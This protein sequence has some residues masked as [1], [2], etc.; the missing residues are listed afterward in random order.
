MA[1]YAPQIKLDRESPVPLYHQIAQPIERAILSG[2]VSP[3]TRVEDEL[4]MAR[5]LQ[6][7]RPTAR[8][9]LQQL[10]GSGLIVRRRGVGTQVAPSRV[11]RPVGLS[12]LWHDIK[13]MGQKPATRIL[14]YSTSP[15]NTQVAR[16]LEV[17][18]GTLVTSISRLRLADDQ[19][20]ALL[21]NLIP[22]SWVPSA[23][24]LESIGLYDALAQ[25]GVFPASARQI[26][27]ARRAS[28]AEVSVLATPA[29]SALLTMER[30]AYNNDGQVVE[31]G[32]HIYLAD[33]YSLEFTVFA[34]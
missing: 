14:Q 27:G 26:M 25:M 11:H 16:Q 33:R 2:E 8:K 31:F 4:S 32:Q 3:G 30:T 21:N 28:N 23:A 20:L 19:P 10:G 7:S 5:R 12:S 17:P 15:A 24:L 9:A 18:S 29:G 6:V 22:S 34:R 1:T 13:A